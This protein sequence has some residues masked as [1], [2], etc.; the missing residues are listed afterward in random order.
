MERELPLQGAIIQ[1]MYLMF[2][3]LKNY[4]LERTQIPRLGDL[5]QYSVE[6]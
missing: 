4:G 1:F 5:K 3:R 6:N 2:E